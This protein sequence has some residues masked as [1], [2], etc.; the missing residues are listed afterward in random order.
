MEKER[1]KWN[2]GE[3]GKQREKVG[4]RESWGKREKSRETKVKRGK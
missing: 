1:K 4:K 2:K 3:E